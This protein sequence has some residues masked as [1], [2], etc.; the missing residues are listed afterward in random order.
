MKFRYYITALYDGSIRGTNDQE[1]ASDLAQSEDFFVVDA[2]AGEWIQP[3]GRVQ[4]RPFG[5]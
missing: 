3:D 4:V 2:E 5:D 1:T